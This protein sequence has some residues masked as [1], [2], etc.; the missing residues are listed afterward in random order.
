MLLKRLANDY[1]M[2]IKKADKGSCLVVWDR[3]NYI[4]E[5]EK[6]LRDKNIQ[7]DV[8]LS[9]K[10]LPDLVDKSNHRRV[11][12]SIRAIIDRSLQSQ[13]KITKKELKYFTY[14]Y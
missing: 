14:E 5:A 8:N 7:K 11:I 12:I 1:S 13:G 6:Q 10:N 2:I 9:D 4:V 3:N